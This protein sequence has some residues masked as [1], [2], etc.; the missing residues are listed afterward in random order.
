MLE[1]QHDNKVD[2]I[3]ARNIDDAIAQ[4]KVD[5]DECVLLELGGIACH[6]VQV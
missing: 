3:H 6:L 2:G 4:L 1:I 5:E